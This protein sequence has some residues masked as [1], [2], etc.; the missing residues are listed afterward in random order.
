MNR[1]KVCVVVVVSRRFPNERRYLI[2]FFDTNSPPPRRETIYLTIKSNLVADLLKLYKSSCFDMALEKQKSL[3]EQEERDNCRKGDFDRYTDK[4]DILSYVKLDRN[5]GQ[6]EQLF[7][8]L[9]PTSRRHT[10]RPLRLFM[11]KVLT[12]KPKYKKPTEM[13]SLM[14]YDDWKRSAL[15]V[16]H[17]ARLQANSQ[18]KRQN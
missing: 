12:R 16:L 7:G 6:H 18:R 1:I 13:D 17:S 9:R 4:T 8:G 3:H 5:F 11:F 2:N 15:E 14:K 10:T